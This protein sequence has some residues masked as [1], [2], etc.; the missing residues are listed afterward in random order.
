MSLRITCDDCQATIK[1]ADTFRGK[2][3]HCP[4]CA[5]MLTISGQ[6]SPRQAQHDSKSHDAGLRAQGSRS[7][8]HESHSGNSKSALPRQ[9]NRASADVAATAKTSQSVPAKNAELP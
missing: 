7:V 5:A 6:Q 4:N 9:A 3:V 8:Q 2:S 1:V